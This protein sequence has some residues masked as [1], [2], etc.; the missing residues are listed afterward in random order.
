MM[1]DIWQNKD[2]ENILS[3]EYLKNILINKYNINN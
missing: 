3:E 1:I 2:N